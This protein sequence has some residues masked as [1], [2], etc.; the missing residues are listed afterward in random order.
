MASFE[1]AALKDAG[2]AALNAGNFAEAV[3][4]YTEAIA[5][6]PTN[7]VFHSNRSAAYAKM[8]EYEKALADAKQTTTL[9][10]DWGKGYGRLGAALCYLNRHEE[11]VEAYET[12]LKH[13]PNNAQLQS[14]LKEAQSVE[15]KQA[16]PFADPMLMQKIA[17]NPQTREFLADP[18]YIQKLKELAS[19][20]SK[21]GESIKDQ[22]IMKTLGVI[23]GIPM[24]F[25]QPGANRPPSPPKSKAKEPEPEPMD[26]KTEEQTKALSEKALGNE[27][28]KRREFD[29]AHLHY[30][31][32]IALEPD[33]MTFILNKSAVFFEQQKWDECLEACEKAIEVGRANNADYA[34]IAKPL[35]RMGNV[36]MKRNDLA[37]AITS[38]ERSLVENRDSNIAKK[39]N[40]LKKRVKE[41]EKLAYQDPVKSEEA[42]EEGNNKFR[43]GK[44]AEAVKDYDEALKRNPDNAKVYSNR[45]ACLTKL[46]S[47]PEAL[48]DLD[49]CLELDPT[50]TKAYLRKGKIHIMMKD[51]TQAS[52]VYEKARSIDPNCDEAL[53][54]IME[55]R[56]LLQNL[57]PEERRANALNDPNVQD[58]LK[59]PAMQCVLDQMKDNPEAAR[60]HLKNPTI[61]AKLAKLV[62][63]GVVEMR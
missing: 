27:C 29:A 17:A 16:N 44:F 32:A 15:Q 31:A 10:P 56:K 6:E 5:L 58:I 42:R 36:H 18:T 61:A 24:D 9:K 59:D 50:F 12:G 47:F 51:I 45:A 63:A 25:A 23:L 46:A 41:E 43:K 39:V 60:T 37:S 30:D 26:T 53:Q 21:L 55:C 52:T 1:A 20:S 7:H 28:Y 35:V 49:K 38:Y 62:E 8:A 54:G 48:R 3:E 14:G 22:R 2:N 19:D 13:D 57:T 40:A 33:N 4:R 11:A 34:E